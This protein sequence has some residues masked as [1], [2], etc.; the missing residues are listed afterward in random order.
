[1]LNLKWMSC[2]GV[3]EAALRRYVEGLREM[4]SSSA[5]LEPHAVA[6][7]YPF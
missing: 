3:V 4:D 5:K 6:A 7:E 1:M 2:L